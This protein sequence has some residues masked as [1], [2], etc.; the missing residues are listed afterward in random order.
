MANAKFD[1]TGIGNAIV[2]TL[3]QT[4]DDVL[5]REG[6]N[7]GGMMLVDEARA[8]LEA[9]EDEASKLE[10]ALKRLAEIG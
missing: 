7:K 5:A 6:L 4:D 9:R 1:I 8:N 3:A 2:D 10:A